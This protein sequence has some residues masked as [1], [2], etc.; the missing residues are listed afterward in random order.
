MASR[1]SAQERADDIR[2]FRRELARLRDEGALALSAEQRA[3]VDGH[4]ERLLAELATSFDIDRDDRAKQ[5][6][7]GMRVASFLGALALAASVFFL[8]Y[9]FWGLLSETTQAAVLV[10]G[11][12][13]SYGLTMW[14]RQRD[15]TG[16]FTNLCAMVAF[17]CFVLNVAMLGR[18][19][20]LTPSDHALAA[21]AAL[22]LLLAYACDSR[23]LLAAGIACA[24]GWI[25]ARV[26]A[27]R[28]IY[29]LDL[30]QRPEN[31]LP[32][33]VLLFLVPQLVDHRRLPGFA[34]VYRV[35][36]LVALFLP[37]LVLAFWG[38]SSYFDADAST[39]EACYQLAGFALGAAAVWL[40]TRRDWPAVFNTG[41]A[42]FVVFLYTKFFDWWWAWMPKYL[43][44]LV[45]GLTAVLVLVVLRR[46]H[47]AR[48]AGS[49][50]PP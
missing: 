17:A 43:F 32:A 1:S 45:L 48:A 6:S 9:Q 39:I 12:L 50:A 42:F 2:V 40:G 11:S 46:L 36:A 41:V 23:L 16:Y 47:R 3:G 25:A 13:G 21:W 34:S 33:A 31:F 38:Q 35:L 5:L 26:G 7:I 18:A 44:F 28:G 10:A 4:H 30:G 49:G 20:N 37:M 27:W 8:F 29:W 15:A 14:V 22:A 19:F 24:L